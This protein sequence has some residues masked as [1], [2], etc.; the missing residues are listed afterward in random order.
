MDNI[1]YIKEKRWPQPIKNEIIL[2]ILHN[3][4]NFRDLAVGICIILVIDLIC[5]S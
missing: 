4:F 5:F 3:V 2:N 1:I